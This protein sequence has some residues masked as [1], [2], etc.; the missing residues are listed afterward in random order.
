[1]AKQTQKEEPRRL[2]RS[3]TNVVLGGVCGG[4]G[5]Y[6]GVDP[7]I[8][9]LLWVIFALAGGIGGFV[10]IIAW[11]IIPEEPSGN[12]T[13]KP[14][15]VNVSHAWFGVFFILLGL[16]LFFEKYI[17]FRAFWPL[18]LILIGVALIAKSTVSK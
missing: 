9:R 16:L 10:Y 18:A 11:I 15:P 6:F 4:I 7:T 13:K 1:M 17:S 14:A 3:R 5:E 8:V 2:Y 12:K